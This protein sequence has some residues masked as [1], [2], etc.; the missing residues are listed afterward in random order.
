M[1]LACCFLSSSLHISYKSYMTLCFKLQRM[2]LTIYWI[3]ASVG[4]K[5]LRL[6]SLLCSTKYSKVVC[7]CILLVC[8]YRGQA[9]PQQERPYIPGVPCSYC[10]VGKQL[11]VNNLCELG[12]ARAPPAIAY[13]TD[14]LPIVTEA[15][16]GT[17]QG[18]Q[19]ET[20]TPSVLV[21]TSDAGTV[22]TDAPT[23]AGE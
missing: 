20:P 16:T 8:V 19:F 23:V 14:P 10:P 17:A 6:Y 5:Y 11:C 4:P 21:H 12:I 9:V 15:Q 7:S 1:H 13:P 18:L 3:R 2:S 22:I